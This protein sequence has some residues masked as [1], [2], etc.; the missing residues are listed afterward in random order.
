[1][2]DS[3]HYFFLSITYKR[4]INILKDVL[5]AER[6]ITLPFSIID[7]MLHNPSR[8][9]IYVHVFRCGER[10]TGVTEHSSSANL[11]HQDCLS[12]SGRCS[13]FVA[14][15]GHKTPKAAFPVR[16]GAGTENDNEKI[17]QMLMYVTLTGTYHV[18]TI[19]SR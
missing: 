19:Q 18:N 2:Q 13:Y 4:K 9:A 16:L 14:L 15:E 10:V 7:C 8:F 3:I 12:C 6:S 11:C 1:M 17:V 5:V